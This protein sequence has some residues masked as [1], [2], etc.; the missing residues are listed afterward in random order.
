MTPARSATTVTFLGT[1][2]SVGVP[3]IGCDCAV[4]T[5]PH[6]GDNRTRCALHVQCG[7]LS[8]LVDSGPDLRLQALREGLRRVDAVFYTHAHLDHLAG[9][10]ELRA[11]CWHREAPLPIYAGPE[12]HAALERMFPWAFNH[13]N[14]GYVRPDPLVLGG[15]VTLGPLVVTPVP[16][17]HGGIETYGFRFDLPG[18]RSLA[19]LSDVKR[20]PPASRPALEGLDVLVLDALREFDHPTHMTIREALAAA[21]LLAP[22][23]TLL[24]HLAHEVGFEALAA[25]LPAGVLPARDGLKLHFRP[26]EP[27]SMVAPTEAP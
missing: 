20:I 6:P 8:L 11:F 9:F 23:H 15:A 17:D 10:D 3:V 2:T 22:R 26:G 21:G 25:D 1:G 14:P 7:E 24:T 18:G 16:V 19:Y 13:Q 5:S 27:C 4:C 12:T